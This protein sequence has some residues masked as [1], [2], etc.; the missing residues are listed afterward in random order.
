MSAPAP[1][2]RMAESGDSRKVRLAIERAAFVFYTLGRW[3]PFSTDVPESRITKPD[4][5]SQVQFNN[6]PGRRAHADYRGHYGSWRVEINPEDG[7]PISDPVEV[8]TVNESSAWV[9]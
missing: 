2:E 6:Q 9:N 3:R 1:G 7:M 4:D 5:R 8:G